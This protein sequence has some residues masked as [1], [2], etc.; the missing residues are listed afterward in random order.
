MEIINTFKQSIAILCLNLF[1][2]NTVLILILQNKKDEDIYTMYLKDWL[3]QNQ[4]KV[5][6]WGQHVSPR[7][8]LPVS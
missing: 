1:K 5:S 2:I 6:Q 3:A 4:D 8:V 7:T